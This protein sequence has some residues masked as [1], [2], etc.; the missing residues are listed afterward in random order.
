MMVVFGIRLFEALSIFF[1]VF[2]G[3]DNEQFFFAFLCWRR[4]NPNEIIGYVQNDKVC[5]VWKH[6]TVFHSQLFPSLQ[7]WMYLSFIMWYWVYSL[8]CFQL[9]HTKETGYASFSFVAV[10]AKKKTNRLAR[11]NFFCKWLHHSTMALWN[12]LDDT[13]I[14][15]VN[16]EITIIVRFTQIRVRCKCCYSI[17]VH[18]VC[19]HTL[20]WQRWHHEF[21]YTTY[22]S[23]VSTTMVG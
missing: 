23:W 17:W 16:E 20:E 21:I 14:F 15:N 22:F 10:W 6:K 4:K 2:C 7:G 5:H 12:S 3:V 18:Q 8:L 19:C 1:G 13:S 9:F 11:H